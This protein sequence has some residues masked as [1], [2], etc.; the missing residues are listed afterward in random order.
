MERP[1]GQTTFQQK[2]DVE[3]SVE[4]LYPLFWDIY[5]REEIPSEWKEG[6]IINLPK[7]G[8]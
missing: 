8:I 6:Y 3:T 5:E 2:S 4:M 1:Q 7:K